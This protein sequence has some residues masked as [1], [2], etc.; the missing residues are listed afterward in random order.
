MRSGYLSLFYVGKS[1]RTL[2]TWAILAFLPVYATEYVGFKAEFSAWMISIYFIGELMGTFIFS[3]IKDIGQ[4][5]EMIIMS[6]VAI[7]LLIWSITLS[8]QPIIII[9][10]IAIIGFVQGIF[11]PSQNVWLTYVCPVSNQSSVFGMAL[12]ADGIAA[13]IAPAVYGWIADQ[14]TLASAYRIASIPVL[15]S[16]FIHLALYILTKRQGKAVKV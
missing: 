7:T 2:G 4:Q 6:T 14:S 1:F 9:A 16:L 5:L 13:T 10:I 8:V 15:I 12:F 3:K 11:F